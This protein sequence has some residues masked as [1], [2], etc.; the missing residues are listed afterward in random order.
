[1]E[2][3]RKIYR[4]SAF[5]LIPAAAVSAVIDWKKMPL[6]ILIGGVL[7]LANLKG[8]AWGVSGLIGSQKATI[9]LVLFSMIRFF[10]IFAVL[11]VLL[12]F[13][14]VNIIGVIVG[15]TIVFTLF[16]KEGLKSAQKET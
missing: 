7:A 4:Q 3:I 2:I 14:V 6:S 10:I 16:L 8:L 11:L 15:L 5:I 9:K 1:M 13:G 12:L